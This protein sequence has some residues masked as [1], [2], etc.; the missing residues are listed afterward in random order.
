MSELIV[1]LECGGSDAWSGV[2]A[3]PAL[4]VA[5]DIIVGYGGT[6]I[7]SETTE[8][9][10]AEH[11]L[12]ARAITPRWPRPSWTSSPPTKTGCS[13]PATT[14]ARPTRLPAT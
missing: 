9:I 14:S 12:A 8:A 6:V 4:G 5:S 3:N 7:L 2:T 13:R 10:G 1:G 11:I